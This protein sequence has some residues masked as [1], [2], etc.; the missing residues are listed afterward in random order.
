MTEEP[1]TPQQIFDAALATLTTKQ[2]RFVVEYLAC[3]NASEAARRAKYATKANV[4][5]AR[6]LANASIQAVIDAGMALYT[7]P[8]PE[9]LYRL[10]EHA[11][12]SIADF[13]DVAETPGDI[14]N[15]R[16]MDEAKAVSSG[17]RLNLAKAADAG[18]LHLV[19]KIKSGQWGPELELY[20]SQAAL[21][22]LG[23]H[24]KLWTD[25]TQVQGEIDYKV[26]E[27]TDS[28]DPDSA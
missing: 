14:G 21:V 7:M 23:K 12:S 28:F 5:G 20:D 18:K 15:V 25:V 26:Y 16:D 1:R 13:I 8:A 2:Q 22:Q 17:W 6:M 4:Q 10:T 11:R 9:V 3:L 19:K 27:R 24:Y